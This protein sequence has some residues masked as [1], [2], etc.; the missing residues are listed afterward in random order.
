MNSQSE[1][2]RLRQQIELECEAMQRALSGF[3][4]TASHTIINQKY[5]SIGA[6]Q[7]QLAA[8]VG[9]EEATAIMVE[10]YNKTMK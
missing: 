2:A 3:A 7:Q 8:L 4:I 6:A 5:A 1:V 9:E 10:A